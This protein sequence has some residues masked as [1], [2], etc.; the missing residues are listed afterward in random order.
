MFSKT[1][2]YLICLL[3]FAQAIK[4]QRIAADTTQPEGKLLEILYADRLNFITVDSLHRYTS[5]AGKVKVKQDKTFFYADSA[6]LNEIDNSLEAFDNIHIN[7]ADSVHTY[8]QY[9]KYLGKEKRAYLNKKV[10]LTDGKGTLTTEELVYDVTLKIGTYVNGGKL[11]NKQT[12]LTSMEGNY[13]GDT[14]DVLFR[15][16]VRLVDPE[17]TII[18]DTLQYN[19]G[20]EIANFTSPTTLTDTSGRIIKTRE[21]FFDRKNKKGMLFKRSVIDDSSY[22]FTADEMAFDDSTKLSEFRGNAVYRGKDTAEGFDMIAN[23]IK[24]DRKKDIL[25]ATEKPI[26]LI[27]QGK[28]SIFIAADTLYSARLADLIKTRRVPVIRDS[29]NALDSTKRQ[30]DSTTKYFEAY[31]N[32]KIFSDSLQAR[33]DSLFYSL[34]DSV[35]RLFTNP[36][37]WAQEN[38]ITGDTIYL[39]L[40]NKK[41]ERLQVFE[42]AMAISR[43]DSTQYYNQ[44]KGNTINAF[45][46]DGKINFL[47]AKGNAENVYYGQ[48]ELKKFIGVNKSSADL[49]DILFDDGKAKQVTFQRNLDGTMYPMR[50]VNHEEIRLRG[51]KW[52]NAIRPKSKYEILVN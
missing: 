40:K 37:V 23:N 32:V 50:Q 51:Y 12:V 13:Y 18:T 28:D 8:A 24:T 35:F 34:Q 41:P 3:F 26:L 14:K 46:V 6:I 45:F 5:L 31:Y 15:R 29:T 9:L 16:N 25:L 10:K 47:R 43:V 30:A 22:T 7:D 21:G 33:G 4:A 42:N 36:V 19:T 20:T 17:Y 52:L 39:Y 48:D 49:I 44:V 2:T 38:Q 27:K 1:V 11:V